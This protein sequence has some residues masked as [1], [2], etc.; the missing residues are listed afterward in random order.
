MA[1]FEPATSRIRTERSPSLSYTPRCKAHRQTSDRIHADFR[2]ISDRSR[3]DEEFFG[4]A[5]IEPT[6]SCFQG[7]RATAT[8]H[9][10]QTCPVRESNPSGRIERPTSSPLDQRDLSFPK[11]IV[12]NRIVPGG[13][14]THH[15]RIE[16]PA[17]LPLSDGDTSSTGGNRTPDGPVNSRLPSHWATV[18]YVSGR[19]SR[20]FIARLQRPA[21]C[22][23]DHPGADSFS[24]F[25]TPLSVTSA[26]PFGRHDSNVHQRIQSPPS[27]RLDDT[28]RDPVQ[29][30]RDAR[31]ELASS[32]W[33]AE[34]HANR[35]IPQI[36]MTS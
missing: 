36:L 22:Q 4:V 10:V 21:S 3:T 1:G 19:R 23:L 35:P 28:R 20:T 31:I 8:L 16:R 11:R 12:S 27:C 9:P 2:K 29:P 25:Q 26:S 18:E 34:A 14:R 6:I 30:E 5:G 32:A 17:D 13:N 7:R 15:C 24:F 33:K